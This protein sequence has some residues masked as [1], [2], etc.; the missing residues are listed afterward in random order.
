MA[1]LSNE[2][3]VLAAHWDELE[4]LYREELPTGRAPKLYDRMQE[5]LR[6]DKE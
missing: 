3:E 6:W 2:W 4:A 1:V 5:L